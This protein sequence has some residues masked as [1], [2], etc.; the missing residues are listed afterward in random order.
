MKSGG[1]DVVSDAVHVTRVLTGE[2]E[3][4]LPPVDDGKNGRSVDGLLEW[5]SAGRVDDAGLASGDFEEGS[6]DAWDGPVQIS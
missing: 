6:N 3:Y 4:E 2:A 1:P 5:G